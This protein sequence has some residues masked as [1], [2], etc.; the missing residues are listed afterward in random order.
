MTYHKDGHP[1]VHKYKCEDQ[2]DPGQHADQCQHQVEAQVDVLLPEGERHPTRKVVQAL[3]RE[4]V[5]DLTD[6]QD[7]LHDNLCVGHV[8][9]EEWQL[10]ID[11]RLGG[12]HWK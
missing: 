7:G 12:L 3:L 8:V 5:T 6:L 9:Q 1:R 2:E 10:G 11:Q 4:G